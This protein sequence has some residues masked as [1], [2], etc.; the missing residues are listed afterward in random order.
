MSYTGVATA[1]GGFNPLAA[2]TKTY[3]GG[4]PMPTI[5]PV[6]PLG[7]KE[8]DAQ[9]QARR[10]AMLKQIQAMQQQNFASSAN[11]GGPL[12]NGY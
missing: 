10:N 1:G 2:G 11:L 5:G 8:R 12:Q 4:R 9:V 6:N 3:G 7:Y